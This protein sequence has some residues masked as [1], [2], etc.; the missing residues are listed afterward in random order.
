M[1]QKIDR[2]KSFCYDNGITMDEMD[3]VWGNAVKSGNPVI[4][5]LVR[6]GCTWHDLNKH[7]LQKI[8]NQ[9]KEENKNE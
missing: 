4:S 1:V 7:L 3:E 2:A 8:Y 9:F 5:Q 6:S